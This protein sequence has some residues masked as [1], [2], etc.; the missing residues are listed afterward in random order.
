MEDEK[1]VK[2]I[3]DVTERDKAWQVLKDENASEDEKKRARA[4]LLRDGKH[5]FTGKK[6]PSKKYND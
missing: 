5:D 1:K 3:F 6:E 4:F 2:S